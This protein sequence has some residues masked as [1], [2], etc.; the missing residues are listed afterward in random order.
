MRT[1]TDTKKVK[2]DITLHVGVSPQLADWLN[3]QAK[4]ENRSRINLVI[5]LLERART[6]TTETPQR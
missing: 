6:G 3:V 1:R 5:N 2:R 4:A